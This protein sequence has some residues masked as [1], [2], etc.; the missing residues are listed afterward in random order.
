MFARLQ[1]L[2]ISCLALLFS[3]S[4]L[5]G[6]ESE[7]AKTLSPYFFVEGNAP[8]V[9]AFP[10][11]GTEVTANVSGVIADV[12]VKQVYRN[13]GTTPIN[14]K[15]VFPASTRAAVHG[16][17][18]RIGDAVVV[19]KIKE[20]EQ[21][22]RE[23]E[24]AKEAGKTA[25][26]LE[27]QR[28]NVFTMS[29][30]NIM[31]A[32][33]VTVELRYS[34]FLVPSEGVYEFVY[35]TVV[36]P[37]YSN[38]PEKGAKKT[39][40]WVKSP[41]LHAGVAP[42]QQTFKLSANLS[43]GMSL[44]DLRSAS[45]AID[46]K[47]DG[48][49]L[50]RVTM[51]EKSF[52]GDRDFVLS[53]R[54]AGNQIQSGL[55]LH[56]DPKGDHF[57]LMVQPPARVADAE[58]PAREYL[59][60]VDV[61]GSMA[62]F[63]LDTAK[64]LI[65]NLIKNLRPTDSFNVLLFAGDSRL[66]APKS[67]AATP[68]NITSALQL[69]DGQAGGGGTELEAA[70]RRVVALPRGEHVSRSV[71][72]ITDGYIAEEAGTFELIADSLKHT[73]FFAFGI[74]AGVNRYLIEGIARAGQGEAFVALNPGEAS[75]A[76]E[77]FRRYIQ[78]PVLTNIRIKYNGFEVFDVEPK[79]QPDLFAER[80]IVVMGKWR[81]KKA[82]SIEVTGRTAK[83]GF[84]QSFEVSQVVVRSENEA[85]PRLWARTRI[86][87]LS[88]FNF[89]QSEGEAA[90]AVTSLGLSYSLLTKYTSF[91]AVLE[92]VRNPEGVAQNVDQPS[93]LPKGVSDLAV[94]EEQ[95][96]SGAEPE[97][98]IMSLLLLGALGFTLL[99]K[100]RVAMGGAA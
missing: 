76:G 30:A 29:V 17:Q 80:P 19:A 68:A 64:A 13:D 79:S 71:V 23:Y 46:V 93:P 34:E 61:S 83:G 3:G 65:F 26:L 81:G 69:I 99:R 11:E 14:A 35:P 100:Q 77:R 92:K 51:N 41:Y 24:A 54:L 2:L 43:T 27:E 10:L 91:I 56:Q 48:L 74:G 86:A 47:W 42:E 8:G 53:Y 32:D 39:D 4:A 62:G 60:V 21:A 28:P 89:S 72:V 5:A 25:S 70:L 22:N 36:G 67:M 44:S 66:L 1:S 45:H 18:I 58:I 37:R 9:E 55:L 95:Y 33:R 57:L 49:S 15:Y 87:R 40:T 75:N 96:V 97:M 78:T 38:M 90:R 31:P 85:L 73:N 84:K 98:W 16:M 59:F 7:P 20:R 88:D 52:A 63:P 82:G 94:G 6:T 50:A 12:V